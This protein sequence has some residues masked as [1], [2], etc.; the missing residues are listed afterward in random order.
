[1]S[2]PLTAQVYYIIHG[3]THKR[4][5]AKHAGLLSAYILIKHYYTIIFSA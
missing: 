1:M 2:G 3:T 4:N 5:N